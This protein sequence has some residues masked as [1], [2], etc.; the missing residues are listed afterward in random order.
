M[1]IQETTNTGALIQEQ[2]SEMLVQ[3]LEA[4]SVVLATN[5]TIFNSSEPLRVPRIVDGFTPTWVG[6]GE[7]IPSEDSA[8]FGEI[9]LMPSNRKSIKAIVRVSNEL[10]RQSTKG[11]SS[12]LQ[13]RLVRDVAN[14]LD[15]ALLT[16]DG[17]DNTV[18]GL[19]NQPGIQNAEL[20]I[21]GT[22]TFLD[23]LAMAAAKEV[24]PN[25]FIVNGADFFELRKLKD[26]NGRYVLQ[27]DVAGDTQYSLF[28]VPVTVTNKMPKGKAILADT[29]QIAV[30]RDI[31][32][33]VT[34]LNERWAEF[35]QVGIRVATRYDM[36]LIHPEGVILMGGND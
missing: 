25:R 22:D 9:K 34:I 13:Q 36:G 10:I 21:S 29:S 28:G 8:G 3:P 20:D 30:V 33:Q 1:T 18:T 24:K 7:E 27:N 15:T 12:V 6:E 5:P 17:S 31:D 11:V 35:D 32:P 19:I 14:A 16:G 4:E 2:V 26:N 23:A